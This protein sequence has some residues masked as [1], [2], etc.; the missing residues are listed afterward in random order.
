M[1]TTTRRVHVAH[2]VRPEFSQP[3]ITCYGSRSAPRGGGQPEGGGARLRVT[4]P[5]QHG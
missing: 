3:N 2:D 4:P 5:L 1:P